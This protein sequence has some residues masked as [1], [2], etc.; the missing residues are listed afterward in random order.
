LGKSKTRGHKLPKSDFTYG[1]RNEKIDGGVPEALQHWINAAKD[2]KQ[3]EERFRL[4]KDYIALNKAAA[5]SGCVT[6]KQN[7]DFRFLIFF[8]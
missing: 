8:K 7:S 6:T 2:S 3:R 4:V 5:R 1:L